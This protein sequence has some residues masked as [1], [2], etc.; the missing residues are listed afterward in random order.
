MV[1]VNQSES[2]APATTE[3]GAQAVDRDAVL[4]HLELLG[5][6]LLQLG[7]RHAAQLGVN[8][9]DLLHGQPR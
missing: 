8:D 6:L 1:V 2:S 9:F 4:L 7:L 3:L 5:Q